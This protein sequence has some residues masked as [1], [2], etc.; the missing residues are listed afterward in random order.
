MYEN[1]EH[2]MH[3]DL[4][5]ADEKVIDDNAKKR[6]NQITSEMDDM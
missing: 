1:M 3:T 6:W 2:L 5:E 4:T